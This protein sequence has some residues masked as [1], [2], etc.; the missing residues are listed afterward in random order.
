MLLQHARIRQIAHCISQRLRLQKRV[1]QVVAAGEQRGAGIVGQQIGHDVRVQTI[2]AGHSVRR[3][4]CP[5]HVLSI[6]LA[7][8]VLQRTNIQPAS[9]Q[10]LQVRR[11]LARAHLAVGIGPVVVH[12]VLVVADQL[13]ADLLLQLLQIGLAVLVGHE[14]ALFDQALGHR[15][16]RQASLGAEHG[17]SEHAGLDPEV[18]FVHAQVFASRRACDA[19]QLGDG[20]Q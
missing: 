16:G 1:H 5:V 13:G 19:A 11:L 20:G 14:I 10:L 4:A 7:V 18:V 3:Q 8:H 6:R 12:A 9:T 2:L 17:R 15:V